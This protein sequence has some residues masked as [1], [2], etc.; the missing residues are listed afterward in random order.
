MPLYLDVLQANDG[1]CLLLR[2]ENQNKTSLILID[3]GPRKIFAQYL[4]PHLEKIRDEAPVLDV[5]LVIASHIDADHITGL[6]DLFKTLHDADEV[7]E[8][9]PYRVRQLWHNSFSDIYGSHA[10]T[11]ESAAITAAVDGS[12]YLDGLCTD[13][14]AVVASVAQGNKLNAFAERVTARNHKLIQSAATGRSIHEID[15]ARFTILGPAE[16][17]LADLEKKWQS[18]KQSKKGDKAAAADY[19]NRTVPN[20]SSIVALAEI[21]TEKGIKRLLLTGDSGGDLILEGL[22]TAGFLE[23]GKLH[24]DLLKVQHHGSNHSVTEDFF[25]Q[26]TAEKY[27]ISGNGKHGIPHSDTLKWLS[28]ARSGQGF[29][30]YLTNRNGEDDLHSRLTAFLKK[31]AKGEPQHHYHF[32]DEDALCVTMAL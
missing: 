26:V 9:A 4:K 30:A 18:S 2:C 13:A 19:L 22:K 12:T 14:A 3:G 28:S 32:R 11:A 1:D 7:G 8:S 27:V 5:R 6:V 20:L 29:D 21:P 17:E 24:L 31:E 25:R 10:K 15:G 23:D 16:K